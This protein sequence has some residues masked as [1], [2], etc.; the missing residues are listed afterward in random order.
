MHISSISLERL[1]EIQ[2]ANF[3]AKEENKGNPYAA[4]LFGLAGYI[5]YGCNVVINFGHSSAAGGLN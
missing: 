5:S 3:K 1:S 2:R 4:G